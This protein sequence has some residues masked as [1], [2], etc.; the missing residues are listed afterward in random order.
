METY[1]ATKSELKA[2]LLGLNTEVKS[3][4]DEL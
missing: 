2:G 4:Y 1:Y 3:N